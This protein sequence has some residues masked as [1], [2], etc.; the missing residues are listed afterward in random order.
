MFLGDLPL[1]IQYI[2]LEHC[3]PRDLAVLSRVHTSVRDVAE[4]ALYSHIC[5]WQPLDMVSSESTQAVPPQL[6]ENKSLFHTF[7]TNSQK[8]SMVKAL[9]IELETHWSRYDA[10]GFVLV[11]LAEALE[12]MPNLVDLRII[13]GPETMKDASKGRI[14]QIIRFVSD[15]WQP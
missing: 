15:R 5:Y 2:I 1:E 11:R 9:Y 4:Y 13:H 14:S 12:K 8:P 3:S 10:A 6:K 7:A